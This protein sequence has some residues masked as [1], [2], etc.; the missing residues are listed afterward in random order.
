MVTE[1][2]RWGRAVL[3]QVFFKMQLVPQALS[4]FQKFCL[5][6]FRRFDG[7]PRFDDVRQMI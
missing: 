4:F 1:A 3:G 2:V 5:P 7:F 6:F